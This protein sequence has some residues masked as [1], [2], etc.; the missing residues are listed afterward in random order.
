MNPAFSVRPIRLLLLG[1][2]L[3]PAPAKLRRYY[4]H[5]SGASGWLPWLY[6]RHPLHMIAKLLS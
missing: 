5:E 2:I 1:R 3:L 4:R 6:L